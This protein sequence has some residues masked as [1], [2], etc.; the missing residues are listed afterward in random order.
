MTFANCYNWGVIKVSDEE[1]EQIVRQAIDDIPEK[2]AA[3][4]KNLAFVVEDEPS[5]EQRKRLKLHKGASL[6]GLYEGLPLTRRAANY[7]L[8]LPD[9]ITIF[10]N[11]ITA[12]CQTIEQLEIQVRHTVWHEVAHYYGLGHGRIRELENG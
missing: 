7:N 10:K 6:Y 1:F 2:Y 3:N 9:K 5:A 11:P 8:V 4:I 12:A